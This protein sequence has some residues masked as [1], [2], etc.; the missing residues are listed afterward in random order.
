MRYLIFLV[1]L[2]VVSNAF[3]QMK[4]FRWDDEVCRY[5]ATY[6]SKKFS[7]AQLRDTWKLAQGYEFSLSSNV[8]AFELNQIPQLNIEELDREYKEKRQA[9]IDLNIINLPYWKAA[10]QKRLNELDQYYKLSRPTLLAYKNP[11]ALREYKGAEACKI[12]YAEPII[13]SGDTLLDAWLIQNKEAR[14]RN[15]DPER[16]RIEYEQRLAS[17]EKFDYAR[18]DLLTFGW[19]NCVNETIDQD[20]GT[21]DGSH[22]KQFEKLFRK[23][24]S[25]CEEP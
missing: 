20:T 2:F 1:T 5:K 7:E 23:V 11:E 12:K 17:R 15:G 25:E 19:W 22:R 10:K 16:V 14:S 13:A 9:I 4:T 24:T 18:V 3:G 8:T 6:D 21:Q